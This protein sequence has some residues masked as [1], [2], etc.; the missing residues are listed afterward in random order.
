MSG[1]IIEQV[2]LNRL[3]P[4]LV[5]AMDVDGVLDRQRDR[6]RPSICQSSS[7]ED[8]QV[9][10][11]LGVLCERAAQIER[12]AM[13]IDVRREVRMLALW[14]L[15]LIA[16]DRPRP[17]GGVFSQLVEGSS[18]ADGL[19]AARGRGPQGIRAISP[20]PKRSATTAST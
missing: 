1:N 11:L 6:A 10:L 14:V 17:R 18:V 19:H 8:Y 16:E 3:Q 13:V 2:Q 12:M 4:G 15:D 9:L 5:Q 7:D 20:Q